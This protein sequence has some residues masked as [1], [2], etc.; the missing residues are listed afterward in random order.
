MAIIK[1]YGAH[2]LDLTDEKALDLTERS[3]KYKADRLKLQKSYFKKFC[4]LVP[5]VKAARWVQLENKI[6][7]LIETQVAA[8]IPLAAAPAGQ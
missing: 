1:D 3:F 2:W 8:E 4:K 6:G 7:L 5:P